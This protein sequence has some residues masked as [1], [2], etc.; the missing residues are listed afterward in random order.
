[1]DKLEL[2]A[3]TSPEKLET[4]RR[5][6]RAARNRRQPS[7]VD[8]YRGGQRTSQERPRPDWILHRFLAPHEAVQ[9][10]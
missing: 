1:M 5:R 3:T 2:R 4:V 10:S 7:S 6:I 9:G 8:Q